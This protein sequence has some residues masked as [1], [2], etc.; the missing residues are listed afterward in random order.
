MH[1]TCCSLTFSMMINITEF[2]FYTVEKYFM[3]GEY[4][5]NWTWILCSPTHKKNDKKT[6][7]KIQFYFSWIWYASFFISVCEEFYFWIFLSIMIIWRVLMSIY[8]RIKHNK[9][10]RV[11]ILRVW[12]NKFQDELKLI[13]IPEKK[14]THTS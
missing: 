14:E 5:T 6:D 13:I 3:V 7:K 1:L 10:I 11:R 4:K 8:S 12:M 2:E 9:I